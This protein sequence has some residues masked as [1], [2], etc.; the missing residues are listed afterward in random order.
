MLNVN[1]GIIDL[2][3]GNL[4]PHDPSKYITKIAPVDYYPNAKADRWEKFLKEVFINKLG[5]TDYE[6]IHFVQKAI[7][8]S[9]SANTSE[10]V[11]FFLIG[12]GGNGKSKFIEAIQDILG[13]YAKQTNPET[14]ITKQYENTINSD[15]A[16][17]NKTRFV[18]AVESEKGKVLAEAQVKQLTGGDK[19][20]ARFLRKEY[21]EFKPEFKIFFSSNYKPVIL[22]NDEG[23]WRRLRIIPFNMNLE[24]E[25]KDRNLSDKLRSEQQGILKW[26]VDGFKL[27]KQEGL[28]EPESIMQE[29]NKYREDMDPLKQF[30]DEM[31]SIANL[32]NVEI[33]VL[34]EQYKSFR[35]TNNESVL[36]KTEFIASLEE[37]GFKKK[38]GAKNKRFMVGLTL[39]T[40]TTI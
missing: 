22:G 37:R 1:N 35:A 19:V 36:T 4:L 39:N 9:L 24:T 17:L 10:E 38:V 15:I 32:V 5:E 20:T 12:N 18:V 33:K 31:C 11:L 8:Y 16:R 23:I 40:N 21:F 13:G 30:L 2:K 25:K 34:Y 28:N 26:A 29:V 7:G 6:L 14:F 27:W 3:T